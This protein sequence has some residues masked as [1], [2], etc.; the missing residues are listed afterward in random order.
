MPIQQMLVGSGGR[1]YADPGQT[2]ILDTSTTSWTVPDGVWSVS[3]VC[4]GAGGG[5]GDYGGGGGGG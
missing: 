2:S 1:V 5:G 3:V 4:I